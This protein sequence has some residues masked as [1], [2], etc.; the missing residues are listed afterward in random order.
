MEM[1]LNDPSFWTVRQGDALVLRL[2]EADI[3][4]RFYVQQVRLQPSVYS[5]IIMKMNSGKRASFP[6]VRSAIRTYSHPTDNRHFEC[7]NPFHGQVPNRLVIALLK[8]TAFN[9]TI[10]ENPFHFGKFNLKTIKLLISGEEYPYETLELDH[11]GSNKDYRGYHRFLQ[12][13]GC[14]TRGQGNLIKAK[15][16]G[17]GKKGNL[18][19]FDTTSNDSLDS[20]VKSEWCSIL[21]PIQAATSPSC[22]TGSLKTSWRLQGKAPSS[23]TCITTLNAESTPE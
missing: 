23:T 12:A 3:K 11:D 4:V 18:F 10:T 14:F 9:G 1:Y 6:T 19:V 13:T 7:D 8:Q 5:E 15:D 2:T 16:W 17:H 21:E 22:C 20:P